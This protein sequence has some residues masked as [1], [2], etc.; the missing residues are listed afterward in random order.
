MSD[1]QTISEVVNAMAESLDTF[2]SAQAARVS[3]LETKL[4]RPGV[5]AGPAAGHE[6]NTTAPE[7]L[8]SKTGE[9]LLSIKAG[10]NVAA[11]LASKGRHIESNDT[12][13]DF[14]RG[15][16]GMKAKGELSLKAL[17]AGTDATGGFL[18]PTAVF[19]NVLQAMTA[20]STCMSAGAKV[21]LLGSEGEGAKSYTFAAV[22]TV[23]T[24]SWRAENG[25]VAESDPAFRA[26]TVVPQSLAFFFKVSRELLADASN[27]DTA[28][29][30]ACAQ[31][32][33][34]ELDR[35][36]LLGTG[37]APQP[38]GLANLVGVQA[39]TNGANGASLATTKHA[40]L[41][42]AT[43][44]ILD[45]DGPMPTGAVMSHRTKIGFNSLVATDGQPLQMP[46]M[47]QTV[48]QYSTSQIANNM[49]VG[50]ATD[51]SQMFVGD[52]GYLGFAMREGISV[53]A[54][55]QTFATTGQVGFFCHARV[56]VFVTHPAV[57]A[58]V[59]GIRA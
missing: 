50:T 57:F 17:A 42:A 33:A 25:A 45:A 15:V 3:A 40:N 19:G 20:E 1:T 27:L 4:N 6:I 58:K 49:T 8:D 32:F 29:R 34:K 41:F 13:A 54:M 55:E 9:P 12:L 35:T 46:S 56:D 2:K 51:C 7:F 26:V 48:R 30:L 22:N 38:R 53:R 14:C 28:M 16:A 47:L 59:T 36:A 10:D 43:Q 18:L 31:A 52:F 5:L 39:V 44:A 11:R 21:V 24:A 37:T 23:P